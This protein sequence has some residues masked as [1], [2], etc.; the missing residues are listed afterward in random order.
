M[1][2]RAASEAVM[3]AIDDCGVIAI[4]RGAF[5]DRIER[6]VDA[7]VAGGVR[8]VEVSLTSADAFQQ[9]DRAV[10]AARGR[11][12]VGAGTVL[13]ARQAA[14][15]GARGATFIVSPVVDREVI[16]EAR[17]SGLVPLPGAASPTEVH[18]AVQSGAPA[19][20]L[21]PGNLLGPMFVKSL[22]G[23]FPGVRLVPTGGITLDFAREFARVG[24]WA[25]GVGGPLVPPDGEPD[26]VLSRA[27]AFVAAMRPPRT[28]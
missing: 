15:A 11:A 19:V 7:L 17:R 1:S 27:R 2:E 10:Q 16:A 5:L 18:I 21:F 3:T 26:V 25:V 14:A 28:A 13:T 6:I 8:A 23:P 9:V 24:A 12:V 22:L 4:L 20:K